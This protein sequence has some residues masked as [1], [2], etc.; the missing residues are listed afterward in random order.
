MYLGPSAS[1][2]AKGVGPGRS[3]DVQK[4]KDHNWTAK[5]KEA[6]KKY[7]EAERTQSSISFAFATQATQAQQQRQE[8]STKTLLATM[9]MKWVGQFKEPL[10]RFDEVATLVNNIFKV[11][12]LIYLTNSLSVRSLLI[13]R[14]WIVNHLKKLKSL[15]GKILISKESYLI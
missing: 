3:W 10:K 15:V 14:Y 9:I 7:G 5:H 12:P 6:I 2:Y 8:D 11:R 1:N 13:N 4:W